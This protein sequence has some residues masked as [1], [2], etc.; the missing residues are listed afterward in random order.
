[1]KKV[2]LIVFLIL[3]GFAI[4][5]NFVSKN[6][7]ILLAGEQSGIN[8][9][10]DPRYNNDSNK[11]TTSGINTQADSRFHTDCGLFGSPQNPNDFAY[12]LQQIFNIIRFLGPILVLIMTIVDLLKV[13]ASE[14]QDGELKKIGIKTLKR[15]IYAVI[16]FALPTLIT[17]IFELIGLYGT[18]VS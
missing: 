6:E 18:C 10:T 7:E 8:T 5:Y 15:A 4:N 16:L 13:T 17:V 3:I 2:V 11:S 12:Y 14:K 9:Q 1:M